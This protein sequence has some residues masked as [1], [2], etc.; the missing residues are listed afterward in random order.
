[1]AESQDAREDAVDGSDDVFFVSVSY[2]GTAYE[3]PAF[4]QHVASLGFALCPCGIR[5]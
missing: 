3:V 1:M 2:K 5:L 4:L